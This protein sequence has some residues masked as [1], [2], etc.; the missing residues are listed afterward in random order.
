MD[1][2]D[3][4]ETRSYGYSAEF[5]IRLGSATFKLKVLMELPARLDAFS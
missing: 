4:L 5:R 1:P 3:K 2:I